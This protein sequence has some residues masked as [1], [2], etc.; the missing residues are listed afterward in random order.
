MFGF[1]NPLWGLLKKP[2]K[3][4]L[5]D[6][7]S[8]LGGKFKALLSS[9]QRDLIGA[10]QS[11]AWQTNIF[12]HATSARVG[13]ANGDLSAVTIFP[14][15]AIE[16][17]SKIRDVLLKKLKEDVSLGA[18]RNAAGIG[19]TDWDRILQSYCGDV[20][21]LGMPYA[22]KQM[23]SE[24]SDFCSDY[25]ALDLAKNEPIKV[26]GKDVLTDVIVLARRGNDAELHRARKNWARRNN[27]GYVYEREDKGY[28]GF[29]AA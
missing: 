19:D 10:I 13:E 7:Y 22:V 21:R 14:V 28:D 24:G 2:L 20:L 8:Q 3:A 4:L 29:K 11:Q 16:R 5:K 9:T 17:S 23:I 12:L 1:G 26:A 25:A 18:A 15:D 27:K 6:Q